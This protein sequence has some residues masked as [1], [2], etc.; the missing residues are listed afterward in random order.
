MFGLN[1]KNVIDPFLRGLRAQILEISSLKAGE[2]ALDVC[3]GSGAQAVAYAE[4]GICA[5]GVDLDKSMIELA[6]SY[7]KDGDC[8]PSFIE[9]DASDLPF[10]DGS[11][12]C[13]SITLAIH[14]KDTKLRNA[15]ISE[16]K[17]VV[18]K[19]GLLLFADFSCPLPKNI[20]GL[21]VKVIERIAGGEH[22]R[23]FR[24]YMQENGLPAVLA[25][26]DLVIN[27]EHLHRTG[28]ILIAEV[29]N[30]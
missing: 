21:S 29:K 17:R 28:I 10:E 7:P 6:E 19:N 8:P 30:I 18:K 14:D 5:T 16:M 9:A 24:E 3:C 15:I 25:E 20:Y 12:D 23:N 11:F 4:K 13:A 22:Y 2:K 1:Y 27:K 26:N